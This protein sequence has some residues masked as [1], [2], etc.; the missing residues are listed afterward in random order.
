[1]TKTGGSASERRGRKTL[2]DRIGIKA[3]RKDGECTEVATEDFFID[4]MEDQETIVK[5]DEVI[6]FRARKLVPRQELKLG[7]ARLDIETSTVFL[8]KFQCFQIYIF[9]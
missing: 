9:T 8:H 2:A 3:K 1:M 4:N 5:D 7:M 6:Y